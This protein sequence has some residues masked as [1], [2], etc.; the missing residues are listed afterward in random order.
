MGGK[1]KKRINF[2]H[3]ILFTCVFVLAGLYFF[4][5]N[6]IAEERF[7]LK[8]A[9]KRIDEIKEINKAL[10]IEM[11]DLKSLHNLESLSLALNLEKVEEVSYIEIK[12]S[13]PLALNQ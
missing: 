6:S 10:E 13:S 2:L 8:G 9:E 1:S 3:I 7:A 12:A 5:A 11:A 4:E